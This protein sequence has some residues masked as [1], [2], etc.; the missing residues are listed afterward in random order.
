MLRLGRLSNSET[1]E[2][3]RSEARLNAEPDEPAFEDP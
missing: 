1:T 3:G 2:N